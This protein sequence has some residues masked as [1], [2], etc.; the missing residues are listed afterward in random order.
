M[1]KRRKLDNLSPQVIKEKINKKELSIK[2]LDTLA[3]DALFEYESEMVCAGKSDDK[4]LCQIAKLLDS[5]NY[6][7]DT[8][9]KYRDLIR[10]TLEPRASCNTPCE[11]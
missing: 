5:V 10:K 3:L 9:Q 4:L 6:T 8:E 7:A 1:E 11:Q 2:Q